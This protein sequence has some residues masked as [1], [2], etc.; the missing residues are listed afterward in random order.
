ML[1]VCIGVLLFTFQKDEVDAALVYEEFVASFEDTQKGGVAK[2]WVK[3]GVVNSD[4]PGWALSDNL[5]RRHFSRTDHL[6]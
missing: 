5:N 1:T 4:T 2:T 3:G 6:D